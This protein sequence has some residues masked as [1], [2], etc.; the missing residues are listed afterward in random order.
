[1]VIYC[2]ELCMV[3]NNFDG[4][5]YLHILR[6]RN[7]VTDELAKNGSSRTMISPGVFMQELHES[8]IAKA[9]TKT[10]KAVE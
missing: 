7:E 2:Q 3:E 5:K 1:M 9:L 10:N 6:E 4:L 8:S